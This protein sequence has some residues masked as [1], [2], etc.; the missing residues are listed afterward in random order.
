MSDSTSAAHSSSL[1]FESSKYPFQLN[2]SSV[3]EIHSGAL[4]SSLLTGGRLILQMRRTFYIWVH[5]PLRSFADKGG[6]NGDLS[7]N[8]N[9]SPQSCSNRDQDALKI[10]SVSEKYP[11]G[12]ICSFWTRDSSWVA[13]MFGCPAISSKSCEPWPFSA[14]SFL[15]IFLHFQV[16]FCVRCIQF[17]VSAGQ[18][19]V[20]GS[21]KLPDNDNFAKVLT[22]GFWLT[23]ADNI[24]A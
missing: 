17:L 5:P 2:Q 1:S 6:G 11:T 15:H 22:C 3:S 20:I 19:H 8:L 10:S 24:S 7:D 21:S 12:A 16:V 23:P 9:A 4:A 13:H 18:N 14:I